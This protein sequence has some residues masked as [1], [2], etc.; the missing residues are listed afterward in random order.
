MTINYIL[1]SFSTVKKLNL[2]DAT[3]IALERLI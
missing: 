2:I 3:G 1:F